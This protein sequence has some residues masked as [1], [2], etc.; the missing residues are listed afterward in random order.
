MEKVYGDSILNQV[1]EK[2][3]FSE[4]KAKFIVKSVISGVLL[5]HENGI[6][7]RDMNPTNV[8]IKEENTGEITIKILD[9][10]VSKMMDMKDESHEKPYSTAKSKYILFTKTGTPLYTAPEM[11]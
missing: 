7:H 9:F 6:V 5:M 2:G 8:F 3:P 10:N 11:Q 1:I 4:A